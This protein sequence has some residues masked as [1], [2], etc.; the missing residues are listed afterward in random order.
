MQQENPFDHPQA[1][2]EETSKDEDSQDIEHMEKGLGAERWGKPTRTVNQFKPLFMDLL[3]RLGR[4]ERKAVEQASRSEKF[5]EKLEQFWAEHLK[6]VEETL[7]SAFIAAD[8]HD[9]LMTEF[10]QEYWET[11]T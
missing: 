8:A 3:G 11:R 4:R 5:I 10:V 2:E 9:T 6:T 1:T 7:R